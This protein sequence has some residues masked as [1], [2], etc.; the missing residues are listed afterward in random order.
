MIIFSTM[1]GSTAVGAVI[2][3][4]KVLIIIIIQHIFQYSYLDYFHEFLGSALVRFERS[5]LPWHKGTRAV[6]LVPFLRIITPV[7]SRL[8]TGYDE[9]LHLLKEGELFTKSVTDGARF[10]L[11]TNGVS[12]L[13]NQKLLG[14]VLDCFGKPLL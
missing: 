4:T 14:Q 11:S 1:G 12:I 7:E 6:V 9:Y 5:T 13:T 3:P 10:S 8:I 2:N